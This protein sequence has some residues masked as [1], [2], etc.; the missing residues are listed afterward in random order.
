MGSEKTVV[1]KESQSE[2]ELNNRQGR[3][4]NI[5]FLLLWQGQFVSALGDIAYTISLGFWI[6][7]TTGSTALMG[8]IMAATMIPRVLIAPF[9][10]VYVDRHS[11]KLLLIV[12]DVIRGVVILLIGIAA[13]SNRLEIWMLFIAAIAIGIGTA[14][15]NPAVNSILPDIV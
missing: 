9:A 3:L 8:T 12:T 14:F 10:G 13:L 2:S 5:N 7:A 1:T 4:W 6:L 11:R 15:F